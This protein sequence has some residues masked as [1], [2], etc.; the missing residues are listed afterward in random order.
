METAKYRRGRWIMKRTSLIVYV[1]MGITAIT[2]VTAITPAEASGLQSLRGDYSILT[3]EIVAAEP[4]TPPTIIYC[5]GFGTISF[6]GMGSAAV[7]VTNRCIQPGGNPDVS[8]DT[9]AMEYTV[10]PDGTVWIKAGEDSE[11]HCQLADGGN[12]LMCDASGMGKDVLDWKTIAVK[13]KGSDSK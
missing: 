5:N 1:L 2:L 7:T 9:L 8:T 3:S 6:D 10:D 4:P 11:I 12:T 13:K